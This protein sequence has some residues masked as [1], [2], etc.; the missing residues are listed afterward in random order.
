M[1]VAEEVRF[2]HP[3]EG[4]RR[5]SYSPRAVDAQRA[6]GS[7]LESP[8]RDRAATVVAAPVAALLELRQRARE[9][10]LGHEQAVAHADV[11]AP[12]DRL[13]GAVADALAEADAEAG[14]R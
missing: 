1:R 8:G 5:G 3:G 6:F 9:L 7:H 2:F 12:A 13:A 11:V 14:L 10:L 4:T